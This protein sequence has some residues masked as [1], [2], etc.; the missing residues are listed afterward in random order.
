[1]APAGKAR[2]RQ[3]LEGRVAERAERSQRVQ[4]PAAAQMGFFNGL[5]YLR[6]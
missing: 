5:L 3:R 6:D 4:G 1:M 2:E